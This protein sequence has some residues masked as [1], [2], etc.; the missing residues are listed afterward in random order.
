[1]GAEG[2]RPIGLFLKRPLGVYFGGERA[3]SFEKCVIAR[4]DPIWEGGK[5][6]PRR[7]GS[8]FP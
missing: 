7:F 3:L 1:M 5:I 2:E 4:P 8:L 6:C